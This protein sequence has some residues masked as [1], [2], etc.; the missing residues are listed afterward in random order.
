MLTP[1]DANRSQLPGLL[2]KLGKM[3]S[4]RDTEMLEQSL[5]KTLGPLLGVLDTSLYR[6][7][8]AHALIR[9]IHHHRSKTVAGTGVERL[10]ESVEQVVN[11]KEVPTE[12]RQITDNVRLLGKPCTRKLE[13]NLL[14][15]YPLLGDE[16]ICGYFVFQ[17]DRE[18]S[19]VEDTTIRGVLEVFSN[20]FTL[21]DISLRDRL[22]G[23]F[24]R[25]A[26]ES[27]FDRIWTALSRSD[28]QG[29]DSGGRRNLNV[30]QYWLAVLDIDHFKQVNDT[31]GHIVGDEVLLLV[32]RLLANTFRTTDL[33]YRYGG[34]EF[35]AIVSAESEEIA[36]QVFERVRQAIET[37]AFPRVERLTLSIGY[38]RA[39]PNIL[40][41]EVLGRADRSLYEAKKQGRNRICEYADLVRRGVFEDIAYGDLELF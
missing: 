25:Q 16:E 5:L 33:L 24:N 40:P 29:E 31:H 18:V 7:D 34:E 3:T 11:P 21:L 39:D 8:E 19:P 22:T 2:G 15:A 1:T 23:L 30:R 12:V 27:S 20:Y 13:Q 14:I 36:R 9:V 38:C 41:Q 4:I 26:L 17:R 28:T 37:Y 35:V 10:V 6:T 32:A